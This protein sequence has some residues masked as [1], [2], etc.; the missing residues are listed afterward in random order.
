MWYSLIQYLITLL[1]NKGSVKSMTNE[2]DMSVM[3]RFFTYNYVIGDT[4]KVFTK[5][6]HS[7]FEI[8]HLI[9]GACQYL[10]KDTI[11]AIAPGDIVLIP[12]YHTHKVS[13]N[14]ACHSKLLINVANTFLP[15]FIDN[16]IQTRGYIYRNPEVVDTLHPLLKNIENE[17]LHWDDYSNYMMSSYIQ[18]FFGTLMRNQNYYENDRICN[19][20]YIDKILS[21]VKKNYSSNITLTQTAKDYSLSPEHLSRIFKQET[22]LTF[23][24]YLTNIRLKEAECLLKQRKMTISEIAFS[25][26]FNDS[27]YFSTK[28]KNLYGISPFRFRKQ[29]EQLISENEK[30]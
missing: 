14:S 28:F 13:Y 6:Y 10:V 24:D 23:H 26:G 16:L 2:Y 29:Y 1:R 27:N 12:A 3:D 8:Y 21:Y 4:S 25:C 22:G 15:P 5:H 17:Y 9:D 20:I 18:V 11:Y 7:W 19:N 30:I